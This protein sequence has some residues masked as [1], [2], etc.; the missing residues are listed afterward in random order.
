MQNKLL[1]KHVA[2][3][4]IPGLDYTTAKAHAAAMPT[5]AAH[6]GAPATLRLHS[7]K[8]THAEALD[9]LLTVPPSKAQRKDLRTAKRA[10][11][12][13]AA[14]P[15]HPP[16]AYCLNWAEMEALSFPMPVRD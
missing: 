2:L 13:A 5:L 15:P 6:F 4:A 10:A 3:V 1:L 14:P 9:R 12:S 7:G 8:A 16:G 11:D